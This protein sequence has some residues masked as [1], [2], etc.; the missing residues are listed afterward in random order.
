MA[1]TKSNANVEGVARARYDEKLAIEEAKIRARIIVER[2]IADAHK[3]VLDAIRDAVFAGAS[4]RQIAI[5]YGTTDA[6]TINRLIQE[7]T[8]GLSEDGEKSPWELKP[9]GAG[10]FELR[11]WGLGD[12]RRSGIAVIVPDDDGKNFTAVDGDLWVASLVYRS[13]LAED[14]TKEIH[15]RV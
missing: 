8:A 13:G 5:A 3:R 1:R 15:G 14:I 12:D 2:D 4:K 11:V 9:I 6:N 7:A 10:E